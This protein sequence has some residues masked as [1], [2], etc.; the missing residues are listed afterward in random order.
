MD[1]IARNRGFTVDGYVPGCC[2]I[3]TKLSVKKSVLLVLVRLRFVTRLTVHQAR[4]GESRVSCSVQKEP[5]QF[6]SAFKI[7]RGQRTLPFYDAWPQAFHKCCECV[8]VKK[9]AVGH[10]DHVQP[11][12]PVGVSLAR[13]PLRLFLIV[14][15]VAIVFQDHL[16]AP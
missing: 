13:I 3:C 14:K 15:V 5:M 10:G 12:Q 6:T 1:R 16:V 4:I 9:L 8:E 7:T 11:E 2:F